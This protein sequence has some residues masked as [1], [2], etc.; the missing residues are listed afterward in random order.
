MP[1]ILP[2]SGGSPGRWVPLSTHQEL[3]AGNDAK[4]A[5]GTAL[6]WESALWPDLAGATLTMVVGHEQYN[7]YGNLP[8]TW[9]GAVS[10][11]IPSPSAIHLDVPAALTSNLP[12]DEYDYQLTATL[13]SG[14]AITI[15]IGKLTVYAAPGTVP[16]YPPAV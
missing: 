10:A 11:L 13:P 5:D 15:A 16:L 8:L 7:L 1:A 6:E 9:T 2:P 12:Q 4:L 3:T 14:D